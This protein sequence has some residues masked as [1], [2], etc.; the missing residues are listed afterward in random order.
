MEIEYDR[1]SIKVAFN[2]KFFIEIL[3]VIENENVLLNI[4]DEE[5]PCIIEGQDDK[6]YLSVIMPMRI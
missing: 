3:N 6:S 5:K 4:V 1:A 2:P